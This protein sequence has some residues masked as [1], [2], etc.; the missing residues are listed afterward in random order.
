MGMMR[1]WSWLGVAVAMGPMTTVKP[2]KLSLAMAGTTLGTALM[3]AAVWMAPWM[4]A[5]TITTGAETAT[6]LLLST[7]T[8]LATA[9]SKPGRRRTCGHISRHRRG[10]DAPSGVVP[11]GDGGRKKEKW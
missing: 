7:G 2:G 6:G 3:P 10:C 5:V 8:A 4:E 1:M 11:V 9:A